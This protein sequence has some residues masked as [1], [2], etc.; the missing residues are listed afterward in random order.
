MKNSK[1]DYKLEDVLL[2]ALLIASK[3]K[4]VEINYKKIEELSYNYS[5]E[6]LQLPA[7]DAPVFPEKLNNETIDFIL[8]GNSINFAFND[9]KTGEKYIHEYKGV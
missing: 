7:W 4:N 2:G 9:F 1:D 3:S 6:D 8:L 5:K